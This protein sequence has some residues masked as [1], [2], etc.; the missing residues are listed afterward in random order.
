MFLYLEQERNQFR[1]LGNGKKSGTSSA[2]WEMG[3]RAEPV[4]PPGKWKEERNQ[5][6]PLGNGKKSGTS[7]APWEMGRRAELVPPFLFVI[8]YLL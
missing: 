5:F 4:P 8:L 2:P 1:P 3:R 6:R 7:S